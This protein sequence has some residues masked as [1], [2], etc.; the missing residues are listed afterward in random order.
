MKIGPFDIEIRPSNNM[1]M[2]KV[3]VGT[4]SGI[5]VQYPH[6]RASLPLKPPILK[7]II[8]LRDKEEID[9]YK[10]NKENTLDKNDISFIDYCFKDKNKSKGICLVFNTKDDTRTWREAKLILNP[11]SRDEN[12]NLNLTIKRGGI[13]I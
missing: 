9:L 1:N 2:R 10:A 8:L 4:F 5:L 12:V 7:D 13:P 6:M 3:V 11:S